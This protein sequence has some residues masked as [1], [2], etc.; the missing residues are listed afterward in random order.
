MSIWGDSSS[1]M[2]SNT[3]ASKV[4]HVGHS[5]KHAGC[6]FLKHH[7]ALNHGHLGRLLQLHAQQHTGK[8]ML[9]TITNTGAI[10]NMGTA[11]EL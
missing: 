2:H 8:Q 9:V 1:C 4:T 7:E 11:R 3:Q 10:T 5:H 6:H